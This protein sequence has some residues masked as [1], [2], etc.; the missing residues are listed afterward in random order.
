MLRW[1]FNVEG[2]IVLDRHEVRR[3]HRKV[4][5]QYLTCVVNPGV[6]RTAL[7]VSK[8]RHAQTNDER[9]PRVFSLNHC[10]HLINS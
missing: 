1:N 9:V 4:K 3:V 5:V 2:E 6:A 8:F 7:S 10:M